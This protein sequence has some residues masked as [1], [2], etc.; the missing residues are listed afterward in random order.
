MPSILTRLE[1][2][3][4]TPVLEAYTMMEVSLRMA[5]NP[6]PEVAGVWSPGTRLRCMIDSSERSYCWW[7]WWSRGLSYPSQF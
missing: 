4:N 2:A 1:E 7:R 5:T 6:L 3:F